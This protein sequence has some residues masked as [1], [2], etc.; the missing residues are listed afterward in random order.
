MVKEGIYSF[1]SPTRLQEKAGSAAEEQHGLMF[2]K[3]TSSFASLLLMVFIFLLRKGVK[4]SRH[5]SY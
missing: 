1:F 4:I 3:N 2:F 5:I